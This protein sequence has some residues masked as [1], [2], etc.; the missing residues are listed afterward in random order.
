MHELSEQTKR[1]IDAGSS[2]TLAAAAGVGALTLSDWALLVTIFA[3]LLSAAWQ[4][5]RF[6]DRLKYGHGRGRDDTAG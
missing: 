3:G 5:M 4:L 6:Y 2:M 1:V